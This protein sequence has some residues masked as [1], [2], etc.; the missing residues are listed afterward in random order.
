MEAKAGKLGTAHATDP[1]AR[2]RLPKAAKCRS[3]PDRLNQ[4]RLAGPTAVS[5]TFCA[6][7]IMFVAGPLPTSSHLRHRIEAPSRD[8]IQVG[9][10]DAHELR[11]VREMDEMDLTHL[12]RSG[13]PG[14]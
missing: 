11:A 10:G 7:A 12:E 5:A 14:V 3:Q 2:D 1:L 4:P 13:H 8:S 6:M 9:A